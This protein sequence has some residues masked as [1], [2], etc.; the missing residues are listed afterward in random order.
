MSKTKAFSVKEA[1][2]TVKKVKTGKLGAGTFNPAKAMAA[3]SYGISGAKLLAAMNEGL[4]SGSGISKILA[5]R[6]GV[7]GK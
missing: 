6:E 7:L 1:L 4:I 2:A 5:V 3:K